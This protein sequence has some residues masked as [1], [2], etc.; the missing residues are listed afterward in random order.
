MLNVL[1]HWCWCSLLG[2]V[3]CNLATSW[4]SGGDV[5]SFVSTFSSSL[6]IFF[7]PHSGASLGF[8][9]LSCPSTVIIIWNVGVCVEWR[10]RL[11]GQ[12]HTRKKWRTGERKEE[13]Q[14]RITDANS[15]CQLDFSRSRSSG[16]HLTTALI[17]KISR[18]KDLWGKSYHV[19]YSTGFHFNYSII[20]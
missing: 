3:S 4:V 12:L 16:G 6:G 11:M 5:T 1:R 9:D 10:G 19:F 14:S 17:V 2:T 8:H 20:A 7:S 18:T 13:K 15:T